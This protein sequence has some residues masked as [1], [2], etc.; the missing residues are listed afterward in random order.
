MSSSL[1]TRVADHALVRRF[2]RTPFAAKI[3]KYAIGSVVALVTSVIVFAICDW[4]GARTG[5]SSA[6]AFIAGAIPN[7]ILN[8]KWAWKMDGRVEWLRE[9]IA[10]T[11]I[12]VLVWAASTWTTGH[13]KTWAN[14]HIAAG[15]GLRVLVT[16]AAYVF[17]QAVFFVIKFVIYDKW[18][19]GGKSRVRAALRSRHQVRSA[20]RANRT[21]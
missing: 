10:Y 13:T 18:V 12:S 11:I 21:P 5:I 7:W 9:I 2:G 3:T 4:A 16:T 14:E 17:V 1:Y 6:A 15:T 20:A 19:F 8:R